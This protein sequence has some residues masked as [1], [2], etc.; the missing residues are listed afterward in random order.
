MVLST[1]LTRVLGIK[2]P[3]VQG[4]MQWVGTAEMVAGVSNA[5]GIFIRLRM[6]IGNVDGFDSTDSNGSRKGN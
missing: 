3:I 5:G 6:R 4:G 1:K 2:H